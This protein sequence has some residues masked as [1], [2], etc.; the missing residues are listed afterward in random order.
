[1]NNAERVSALDLVLYT[2]AFATMLGA[3]VSLRRILEIMVEISQGPLASGTAEM[4]EEICEGNSTLSAAMRQRPHLFANLYVA[5]VTTGEVGGVLDET[6]L[7][8][9]DGLESDWADSQ[10]T[11]R[12]CRSPFLPSCPE[13]E[14]PF[15]EGTPDE[16]LRILSQYFRSLATMIA[17]GVPREM[18]LETAA[19]VLPPGPERDALRATSLQV[20]GD[21][22][23]SDLMHSRMPFIPGFAVTLLRVGEETKTFDRMCEKVARLL[24]YQR[25]H[26]LWK[27]GQ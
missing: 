27:Q 20:Q 19:E 14:A 16:K 15:A 11:G 4:R 18:A 3:G 26:Y 7:Q 2:R 21:C 17:A 23:V 6:L 9:A 13:A 24:E 22:T 10:R 1:M 5:M 12:E 25:R 8:I